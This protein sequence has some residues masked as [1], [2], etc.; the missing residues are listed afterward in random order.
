M[1][2]IVLR[3]AAFIAALSTIGGT[4]LYFGRVAK[5]LQKELTEL[6]EGFK[7]VLRSEMLDTYYRNTGKDSMREY[8]AQNFELQ[9]AAYKALGGNSFID[10]VY[11]D[12]HKWEIER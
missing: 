11:A 10:K 2:E 5:A 3:I 7:C 6:R 1:S 12:V 9:Y 8:E 4:T